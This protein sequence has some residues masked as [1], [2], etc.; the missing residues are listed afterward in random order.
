[1]SG[2]IE[3]YDPNLAFMFDPSQL[4]VVRRQEVAIELDSSRLFNT[5][6]SEIRAIARLD[7]V[8]PNPL[9]VV[10]MTGVT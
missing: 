9:A 7:L 1:V 4:Y 6:S 8:V 10:E 3:A 5:D 2:V